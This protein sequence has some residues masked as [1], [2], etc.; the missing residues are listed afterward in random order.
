MTGI[1][2]SA[3]ASELAEAIESLGV[4]S[5]VSLAA[6]LCQPPSSFNRAVRDTLPGARLLSAIS[7]VEREEVRAVSALGAEIHFA[8]DFGFLGTRVPELIVYRPSGYEGKAVQRANIRDAARHLGAGGRLLVVTHTKR[9]A[10]GLQ[11]FLR[12]LFGEVD[13]VGRGHGG[14]RVLSAIRG[15]AALPAADV[16]EPDS[17]IEEDIRGG[18]FRFLTSSNVFSKDRVD[19]GTRFLL[20]TMPLPLPGAKVLDLGCGYGVIGIVLA[21][22]VA[23]LR[24][25]LADVNVAAVE[26]TRRNCTLNGVEADVVASDGLD[27]LALSDL[28]LVVTHFPLHIE[29]AQLQRILEESR[30]ALAPGGELIGV[31]LN[32]YDVRR[33]VQQVFGNV[34]TL[35][36]TPPDLPDP[37]VVIRA[38]RGRRR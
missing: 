16:T 19:L 20:E 14:V 6:T 23:G 32:S 3:E 17:P 18:S 34:L 11:S 28:S 26:L 31:A 12:D 37:Y 15:A 22:L 7:V 25:T 29:A 9:G 2:V 1:N 30:D 10:K 5:S 8:A 27:R 33:T 4:V 13:V 35:A 38:Q 36:S 24:A 21:R